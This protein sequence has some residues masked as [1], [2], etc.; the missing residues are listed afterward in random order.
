M[1]DGYA[2]RAAEP[3][4]YPAVHDIIED[5]FLEWSERDRRSYEDFEGHT[6]RRPGFQPWYLRVAVDPEGTV[7]G[8]SDLSIAGEC[9]F[10]SQ[11]A[12]RRDQRH[13]GLARAL[14]VDSFEV[15]RAHGPRRGAVDGLADRRSRALREGRHGHHQH[16]GQPRH[17]P[18]GGRVAARHERRT[19]ARRLPA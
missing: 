6:L 13:K 19:E 1:P 17:R 7:V 12:V 2:V 9:V 11:L 16:L 4:E 8:V 18:P 15:G 3:D 14:L 10:V 5:A